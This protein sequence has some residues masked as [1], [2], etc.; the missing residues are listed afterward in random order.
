[1]IK[2]LNIKINSTT[3]LILL[4]VLVAIVFVKC[5]DNT[6]NKTIATVGFNDFAGSKACESCHKNIY[7]SHLQT[8]HFK[9]LK[10]A[11]E[12]NV[13]GVFEKGNNTFYYNPNLKIVMEKR[14]SGFYQVVYFNGE[15][16]KAMKIDMVIG[17]GTM[18]QSFLSWRKDKLFQ[19]PI[20][21][22]TAANQWSNS[23]GLPSDKVV[24]D[25]PVTSRCMECHSTF[26]Q[27]IAGPPLEPMDFDHDKIIYEIGCE[28]CHEAGQKHIAYQVQNPTIKT[29]KYS[30]PGKTIKATAIRCLCV[31]PWWKYKENKT[32]F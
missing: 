16:K 28:K 11:E 17:S 30:E 4:L 14:D 15:E 21:F 7:D 26:A 22:F 20:T 2:R 29:G 8:A 31:M 13:M 19:L 18:G 1:M 3:K 5:M 27:T 25:K 12:K 9:T 24:I 23:P 32:F 6:A 10:T